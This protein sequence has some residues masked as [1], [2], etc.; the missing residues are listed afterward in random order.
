MFTLTKSQKSCQAQDPSTC[1]YHGS[2]VTADS[3]FASYMKDSSAKISNPSTLVNHAIKS[4]LVWNGKK[5]TWWKKYSKK[6]EAGYLP[7][8][9]QII[10]VLESPEGKI[11]VVWENNSQLS[12][13]QGMTMDSGYGM[14]VCYYKSMKTGETLGYIKMAYMDD[15]SFERCFGNDEFTPF[16]Y[17]DRYD[18]IRSDFRQEIYSDGYHTEPL[19]EEQSEQKWRDIWMSAR[20]YNKIKT[21]F[22][23]E[24]GNH[25][26]SSSLEEQHIPSVDA[27][28]KDL[29]PYITHLQSEI[30]MKREYFKHPYV[31]FSRVEEPLTGKGFG[32][33]LYVYTARMLG[34]QG[35]ILCGSSIKSPDAQKVWAGLKK[36]LTQQFKSINSTWHGEPSSVFCLDFRS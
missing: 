4:P 30:Q 16:R 12:N 8:T 21:S 11:A 7:T 29:S 6:S 17:A 20:Q 26:P 18:G 34:Q 13:D 23:D 3:L 15:K 14:H 19:S 22:Y 33:A 35:K 1:R 31:D 5:P 32:T 36:K 25:I 9:P 10:D 2:R 24:Q 28:K 27:I